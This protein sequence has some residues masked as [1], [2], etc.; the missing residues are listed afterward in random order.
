MCTYELR[1]LDPRLAQRGQRLGYPRSNLA[2][3]HDPV[4]ARETRVRRPG[5]MK[6]E[7]ESSLT[8]WPYFDP[9][10]AALKSTGL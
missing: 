6:E 4:N 8:Y 10:K 9:R 5:D 7:L 1:L 3:S 2:I